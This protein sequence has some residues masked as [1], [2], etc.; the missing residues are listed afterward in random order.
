MVTADDPM[1]ER[2]NRVSAEIDAAAIAAGRQP[3]EVDCCWP[4][5]L[6]RPTGSSPR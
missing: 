6:N 4:P 1:L 3:A 5:K 2:L